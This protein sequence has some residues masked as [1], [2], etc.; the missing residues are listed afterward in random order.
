MRAFAIAAALAAFSAA[1]LAAASKAYQGYSFEA[2]V[3]RSD[4]SRYRE[5]MERGGAHLKVR[6]QEE[7]SIV[8]QNPLPVR[9]AVAVSI[10]GLNSIDGARSTPRRARKW[11]ID[12]H[13]SITITGWQ[14]NSESN[15]KFV[16]TQDSGSY[17][18]WREGREGKPYTRNLGVIGVAWTWNRAEL[19]L[20]LHPPKPF[21][22]E[23]YI[24][25][26]DKR[27]P[28]PSAAPA[29]EGRAGTGMGQ[30][31][32]NR[33]STVEFQ[34][35]AGMFSVGDV[36]SLFYEFAPEPPVPQPFVGEEEEGTRFTPQMP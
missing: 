29:A 31:Q 14:I 25:R 35:D 15:R 34:A 19:D 11:M 7:Y 30:E 16:F 13:G 5:H 22:D 17:A 4:G 18:Q 9:A 8:V 10:D 24:K 3:Q 27:G 6:P 23:T 26:A 36:L 12:P 21:E 28:A 1:P 2:W 20:A 33:V 32:S